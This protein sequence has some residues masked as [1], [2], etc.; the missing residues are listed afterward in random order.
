MKT[1]LENEFRQIFRNLLFP[2]RLRDLDVDKWVKYCKDSGA[3]T[4]FLD[5]K[6][7]AYA[8]YDSAVLR[9]DPLLGKRDLMTELAQA[10]QRHKMKWAAYITPCQ[11]DSLTS[12]G[13]GW[14]QRKADG[15]MVAPMHEWNW[16][17]FCWNSPGFRDVFSTMI[18]EIAEKY[19]PH[20]FYIDGI[21]PDHRACYCEACKSLYRKA[22]G[23]DIP[24]HPDWDSPDW[25]RYI[26]WRRQ[27]MAEAA[28]MIHETVRKVDPQISVIYNCPYH[29]CGWYAAQSAAQAKWL[30]LVGTE[31]HR[32]TSAPGFQTLADYMAWLVGANRMLKGGKSISLYT[33][34]SPKTHFV[35]AATWNDIALAAGAL[36]CIQEHCKFMKPLFARTRECEPYLVDMVSAADVAL[37]MSSIA[38]DAYYRP[39]DGPEVPA[40]DRGVFNDRG[41]FEETRGTFTGLSHAH[42][43]TEL[44]HLEDGL[45]E[46]DLSPF[47]TVVM[48]NSVYLSPRVLERMQGY[49]KAGGTLVA[50]ME[51]GLRDMDGSRIDNELLWPGSGLIFK[52]EIK[53]V[54]PWHMRHDAQGDVTGIED[55]IPSIPD[56]HLIFKD[57][58]KLWLGEDIMLGDRPDGVEVR[59]GFQFHDVPSCQIPAQAVEVAADR[60]WDVKVSMRFRRSKEKG[61]EECPAVAMRPWG[62]GRI[63]YLNFQIGT[64]IFQT[65]HLWWKHLLAQIVKA[66]AGEGRFVAE[67][68]SCVKFFVWRQ[69]EKGRHLLHLVNELSSSGL[70]GL[71]RTD[72]IPVSAKVRIALP[73]VTA[74]RQ[75][76]GSAHCEINRAGRRWTVQIDNLE[77]RVIL[78][79]ESPV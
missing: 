76:A 13:A 21:Y 63:C 33:E 61:W 27:S 39:N 50:T 31:A 15:S 37:H 57:G 25:F 20:G 72:R 29:S 59:E 3:T 22:A 45:E 32:P 64:A 44:I 55:C 48:P 70:S 14:Q 17:F 47:R 68:P 1:Y 74:V 24:I 34:F 66:T 16:T 53:T 52:D 62:K 18:T 30:D 26:R 75:V 54:L 71:Q 51:T 77:D 49:V 79:C 67:A 10:A 8:Y 46:T 7:H 5:A 56:Q 73:H 2:E 43:P 11:T 28:R 38:R 4:V 65:G 9:K 40:T 78:A 6:P 19:H 35:E 23:E 36:P 42:L 69:P 12:Q 41:F 60:N 58:T